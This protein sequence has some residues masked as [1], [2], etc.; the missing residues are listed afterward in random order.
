MA[1]IAVVGGGVVG[2]A[3]AREV[4]RSGRSVM[5]LE[6]G[7]IGSGASSSSL[8]IMHGGF[9]YLQSLDLPRVVESIRAQ[10]Y[11]LQEYPDLVQPLPCLMPLRAVGLRSRPCVAGA[12]MLHRRIY[13]T[14]TGEAFAGGILSGAF[15]AREVPALA[16]VAPHGA[17]LWHDALLR[18]PAALHEILRGE[19]VAAGGQVREG[20]AV[21]GVAADRA[22]WALSLLSGECIPARIVI[23]A[24]GPGLGTAPTGVKPRSGGWALGFNL[25]LRRQLEPVYGLGVS[26]KGRLLFLVPRGTGSAV[27][28]GYLPWAADKERQVPEH[29]V[30]SFLSALNAALPGLALQ[31]NDVAAVE[32]AL[33]PM[34]SVKRGEP[35][36]HSRSMIEASSGFLRVRSTKYTTFPLLAR[37]VAAEVAR[38]GAGA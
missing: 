18:D 28:T 36:L 8:R 15:I 38:Q 9:R 27:G 21:T 17:L 16:P 26:G 29:A 35:H 32:C 25:L 3:I 2:L 6:R 1:E 37:A 5:V 12:L 23:D 11:L 20:A 10:H 30:V 34:S 33:L 31:L 7:E 14:V 19:V 13:R 22:G 4:A 24:S